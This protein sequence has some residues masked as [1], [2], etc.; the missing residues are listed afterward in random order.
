M[1][2]VLYYIEHILFPMTTA[3]GRSSMSVRPSVTLYIQHLFIILYMV[4]TY[5]NIPKFLIMHFS[6]PPPSIS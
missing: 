2:R 1:N 3:K 4:Y 5:P 6:P